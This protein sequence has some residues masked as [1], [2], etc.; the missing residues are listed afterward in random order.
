MPPG[1]LVDASDLC[2]VIYVHKYLRY[3]SLIDMAYM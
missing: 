1:E 3:A 2:T